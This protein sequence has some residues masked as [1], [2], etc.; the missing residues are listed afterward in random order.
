[1]N[2][3]QG[4]KT[5]IAIRLLAR[6]FRFVVRNRCCFPLESQSGLNLE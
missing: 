4:L 1:M 5:T 3:S 2:P 6:R